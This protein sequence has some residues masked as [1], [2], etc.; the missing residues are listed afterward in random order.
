VR[1]RIAIFFGTYYSGSSTTR[2]EIEALR[3]FQNLNF[4]NPEAL[5]CKGRLKLPVKVVI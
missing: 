5:K 4:E 2:G 1:D 3:A